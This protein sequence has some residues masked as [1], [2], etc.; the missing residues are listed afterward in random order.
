MEDTIF[1]N[2]Y[3]LATHVIEAIINQ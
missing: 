2:V 1:E 3:Y